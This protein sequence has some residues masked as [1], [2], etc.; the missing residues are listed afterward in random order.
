MNYRS[1][2]YGFRYIGGEAMWFFIDDAE[3]YLTF[4]SDTLFKYKVM[5]TLLP[6]ALPGR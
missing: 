2:R 6:R 5:V 3:R 4:P 1:I